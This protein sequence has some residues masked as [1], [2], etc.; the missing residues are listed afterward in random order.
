MGIGPYIWPVCSENKLNQKH[1]HNRSACDGQ[2]HT[3][4][5]EFQTAAID[6]GAHDHRIPEGKAGSAHLNAVGHREKPEACEDRHGIGKRRAQRGELAVSHDVECLLQFVDLVLQG[7]IEPAQ[8]H[9]VDKPVVDLNGKAQRFAAVFLPDVFAPGDAR[10]G[11]VLVNLPLI[12]T[13]GK[14]EPRKTRDIDQIVRLG[15]RF[16][17]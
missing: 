6:H 5:D 15:G 10:D 3:D 17:K 9:A 4:G 12:R 11:V 7:F 8:M 2:E 13:A 16:Q 14:I 1:I